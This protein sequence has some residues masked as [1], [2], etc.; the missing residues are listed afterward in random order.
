MRPDPGLGAYTMGALTESTVQ[1]TQRGLRVAVQ[2]QVIHFDRT[3]RLVR[4]AAKGW[5]LRRGLNNRFLLVEARDWHG[6]AGRC[7]RD[8]TDL[9]KS[10]NVRRLY[11]LAIDAVREAPEPVRRRW[12]PRLSDW[13]PEKLA[14]D[15]S[16]FRKV[17]RS[18][19]ILPPDQY[20]SVV[21]QVTE[22]CSYNRCL[23]CDFYRDR[24]FH[25]KS[26][27]ELEI[28]LEQIRGFFGERLRE[29]TGIFLADGNAFII[30][31]ARLLGVVEQVRH[32][33]PEVEPVMSAF[34]DTF[35]SGGKQ[36][37]ELTAIR[38]AGLTTVYIG[39]ETGDDGLR[40]FLN[41]PGSA[42]EALDVIRRCKQAGLRVGI[43]VLV[44]A[45][46]R[47]FADSH[48]QRTMSLLASVPFSDGDV[49]YLSPFVDPSHAAYRQRLEA[50]GSEPM[51]P[52]QLAEEL[53]RWQRT[54]AALSPTKVTFY[55]VLEHIY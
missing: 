23:F 39:L 5:V 18:I 19:S 10:E 50:V 37:A 52:H 29:R 24:P 3:G 34:M 51:T 28:H 21:V 30:P 12:L 48:L 55:S 16:H 2:G 35:H 9:E 4:A 40:E 45:G 15:A 13:T 33:L 11:R 26:E 43:I 42:H 47:R 7:Y 20:Q 25:I 32:G 8:L 17:Y 49:V 38:R 46:G 36:V 22:G 27:Q 1:E 53:A 14:E 44:G 31:T 6:W 54:L 41:K